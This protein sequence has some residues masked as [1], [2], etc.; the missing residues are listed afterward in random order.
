M[1]SAFNV[2]SGMNQ[3][4]YLWRILFLYNSPFE[5]QDSFVLVDINRGK[6]NILEGIGEESVF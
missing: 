3:A 2:P 4:G 5:F 1:A 6:Y